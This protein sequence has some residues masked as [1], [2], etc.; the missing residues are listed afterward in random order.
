MNDGKTWVC[1]D[2]SRLSPLVLAF[3]GDSV[4]DLFIRSRLA[5]RKNESAHKMH[6]KAIAY[7]KA[8]AQSKIVRVLHEKLTE[9]EKNIF[10]RGRNTKSA[11]VPKN[12]DIQDYRRATAFEAVL[13]YLY[14]LGRQERLNELLAMAAGIIEQEGEGEDGRK[15]DRENSP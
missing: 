12:A 2:V 10:R 7:V 11:T 9:E 1:S 6:V 13:G 14:L 4:F 5:M 3:V 15:E 8:A